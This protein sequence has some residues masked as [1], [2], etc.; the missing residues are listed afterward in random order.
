MSSL[1]WPRTRKLF[2]FI[3]SLFWGGALIPGG[4]INLEPILVSPRVIIL[5]SRLG[6]EMLL[7]K[8]YCCLNEIISLRFS[9][10]IA[11]L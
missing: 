4:I 2:V 9:S 7:R 3:V 6:F 11:A 1:F 5:L 10:V 8:V